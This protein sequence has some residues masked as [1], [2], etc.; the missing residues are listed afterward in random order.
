MA[1]SLN[2]D[3]TYAGQVAGGYIK[4]AFLTNDTLQH[5]TVRENIDWK[6]VVRRLTSPVTF[7]EPTCGWS[8][9]GEVVS[10]ERILELK[11]FQ[12]QRDLCKNDFLQTWESNSEQNGQL[13]AS[14][15]DALIAVMMGGIGQENERVIWEGNGALATEYAGF[16]TQ[17]GLDGD[18]NSF[19]GVAVTTAT[20]ID[21]IKKVIELTPLAVRRSNEKPLIYVASDVAEAYRNYLASLGNGMFFYSGDAIKMSWIG[22]YDIVECVGMPDSNLVMAQP[23]NLWFGTN[24]VSDWNNIG[25][26]DMTEV[27]F[28]QIVKFNAQFFAGCQYG[29]AQEIGWYYED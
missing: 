21:A 10:D 5:I 13:H 1:T 19:G 27:D 25:V 29:I 14:L 4:S 17:F 9:N 22:Q 8:P 20:V 11:K 28:T 15:R 12:V 23:S 7:G 18:I 24:L 6:Q 3:T 16:I 2:L 26:K